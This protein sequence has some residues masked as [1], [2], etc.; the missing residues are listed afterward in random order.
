MIAT[1]RL[2]LVLVAAVAGSL[3][4]GV[5]PAAAFVDKPAPRKVLKPG[6]GAG[7]AAAPAP[8]A[9]MAL[10]GDDAMERLRQRLS[11]RLAG[12]GGA[13]AT[14][15]LDLQ[16]SPRLPSAARHAVAPPRS[17]V[18]AAGTG[19]GAA[20]GAGGAGA[21]AAV[22]AGAVA[23]SAAMAGPARRAAQGTGAAAANWGYEGVVGPAAWGGLRP[24]F[25]LCGNGQRQSPIDIRGGLAVELDAVKF[26]YKPS[27]FG[28]IDNGH[29]VQVNLPP[30]NA[31]EVGGRRY[32]LVQ[33]HFHRPSEERIDGRQFEMSLH[34]VHKDA[35][36]KLAVVAV[37]LGKGPAHPAVQMVWN[38]LPLEKHEESRARSTIDPGH[39]LPADKRYYTYMGS[40]TT[41]PCSE[42][43]LW[44]VMRTPVTLAE[45][46]LEL[47][48][49]IYPMNA[50][51]PQPVAGRRIMQSQ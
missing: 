3:V 19:T 39:L 6:E 4:A 17:P 8:A 30:G 46:Q 1:R 13:A 40:L 48:A 35:A 10:T 49:R 38:N 21:G 47:F 5:R 26:D 44:V 36:G 34:L 32:E 31:I 24:D 45:E 15:T 29:T 11:E 33:F 23:P 27:A 42:G 51:P 50:R 37:L 43:V 12:P 28:V 41:P 2:A 9:S 7:A 14:G 22:A 20:T 16:I 25:H 18:A